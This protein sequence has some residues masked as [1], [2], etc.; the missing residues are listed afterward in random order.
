MTLY[1]TVQT[2]Q[3]PFHGK[4]PKQMHTFFS[5]KRKQSQS[6]LN[7]MLSRKCDLTKIIE[8]YIYIY[9]YINI[10][11]SLIKTNLA[12]LMLLSVMF[13]AICSTYK[14]ETK[15]QKLQQNLKF[16]ENIINLTN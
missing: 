13:W 5:R 15:M 9:L 7:S 12:L 16:N 4:Y 14:K 11:I 3:T 8:F 6:S 10:Y 2:I 1:I